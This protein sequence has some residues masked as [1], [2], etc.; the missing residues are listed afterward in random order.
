MSL[1][2]ADYPRLTE[3]LPHITRKYIFGHWYWACYLPS[4]FYLRG[5]SDDKFQAFVDW[6]KAQRAFYEETIFRTYSLSDHTHR[7]S[8]R[9]GQTGPVS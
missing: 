3:E 4:K 5:L 8:E 2:R 6:Y 9:Q 7:T 1:N